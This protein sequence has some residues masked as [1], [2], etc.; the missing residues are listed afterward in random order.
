[1]VVSIS[2]TKYKANFT[3]DNSCKRATSVLCL[4]LLHID[5]IF[6]LLFANVSLTLAIEEEENLTNSTH[7]C[8]K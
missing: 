7:W 2:E 5:G 3:P 6:L 8:L 1:M 4:F